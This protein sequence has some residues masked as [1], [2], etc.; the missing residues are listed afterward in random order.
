[1]S[2][3]NTNDLDKLKRDNMKWDDEKFMSD[4]EMVQRNRLWILQDKYGVERG[5]RI[6]DGLE[7]KPRESV[8]LGSYKFRSKSG[9]KH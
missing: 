4:E 7:K 6:F 3:D 5:K 8:A 9:K 2:Y 1:M